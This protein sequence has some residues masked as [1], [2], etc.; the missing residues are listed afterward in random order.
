MG[1]RLIFFDVD[2]T[3]VSHVG[4]SHIPAATT[5]AIDLLKRSGHIVAIATARNLSMT[6]RT[7]AHF[8]IDLLV[9]CDGAH[10]LQGASPLHEEWLPPDFVRAFRERMVRDP[11]GYSALDAEYVYTGGNSEGFRDYLI[12]QTG[13]DC[14]RTPDDFQKAYMAY[15]F[16]P[17]DLSHAKVEGFASPYY[18]EYLPRGVS[19]WT[20]ILHAAAELGFEPKDIVTV[21]DGDNDVEM[22][23]NAGLGIAVAKATPRAL[24]A[25]DTTAPDIDE[26]G[27][28]EAF[29]R[30]NMI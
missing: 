14:R 15:A 12:A 21:G 4:Q 25:A 13:Y 27:I 26:G 3:L 24:A 2:N 18:T 7:A 17:S 5:E 6:R 16:C 22:L 9:C 20:G 1:R 19:K 29:K 10:V 28:L 11:A 23:Q 8:G 30:L